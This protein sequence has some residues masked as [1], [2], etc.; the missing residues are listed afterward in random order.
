MADKSRIDGIF[1]NPHDGVT[2]EKRVTKVVQ[3]Y[4]DAIELNLNRAYIRN[5]EIQSLTQIMKGLTKLEKMN[6][7]TNFLGNEGIELLCNW[8]QYLPS[9]QTLNLASN[10]FGIQGMQYLSEIIKTHT[11][12]ERLILATNSIQVESIRCLSE[13]LKINDHL[14]YLDLSFNQLDYASFQI[15]S[16]NISMHQS[17]RHLVLTQTFLMDSSCLHLAR[18]LRTNTTLISLD[19]ERNGITSVGFLYICDALCINHSLQEWKMI[20]NLIDESSVECLAILLDNNTSLKTFNCTVDAMG[21]EGFQALS[22]T[23]QQ[24]TTLSQLSFHTENYYIQQ[25]IQ[26]ISNLIKYNTTLCQL[27]LRSNLLP[28]EDLILLYTSLEI[29]LSLHL[30]HFGSASDPKYRELDEKVLRTLEINSYP[31]RFPIEWENKKVARI[32]HLQIVWNPKQHHFFPDSFQQ[33]IWTLLCCR[34]RNTITVPL[35]SLP[36][37]LWMHHII[38]WLGQLSLF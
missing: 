9:L 10:G 3:D 38:P 19:C 20:E 4:P 25:N 26:S 30:F 18:M 37:E 21:D 29:N 28:E 5:G 16:E 6:L 35:L 31:I 27:D 11:R 17:L 14:V 12:L 13:A 36:S 22:R 1:Y 32:R 7:S 34:K 23:I 8:I 24:N 15:L 33:Q 2:W